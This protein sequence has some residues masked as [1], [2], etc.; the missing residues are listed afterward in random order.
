MGLLLFVLGSGLALYAG[1]LYGA[2]QATLAVL[3]GGEILAGIGMMKLLSPVA[4]DS[5]TA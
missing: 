4:A 2:S 3:A 1:E 5:Q